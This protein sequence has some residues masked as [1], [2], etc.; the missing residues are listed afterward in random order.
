MLYKL[1]NCLY[2]MAMACG[3]EA[4]CRLGL[5]DLYCIFIQY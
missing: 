5:A 2:N 1:G 3:S 4:A